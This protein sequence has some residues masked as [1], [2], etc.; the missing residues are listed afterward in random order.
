MQWE[1]IPFGVFAITGSLLIAFF[2]LIGHW[3]T[4]RNEN[5]RNARKLAYEAAISE[6][7][8]D[9]ELYLKHRDANSLSEKAVALHLEDYILSHLALVD[10]MRHINVATASAEELAPVIRR[11]REREMGILALRKNLDVDNL[12]KSF[13]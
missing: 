11:G 10:E 4:Q 6:W 7:K 9:N 12:K 8:A 13:G 2:A 1:S 3:I 5:I